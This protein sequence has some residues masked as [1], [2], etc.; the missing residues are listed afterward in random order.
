MLAKEGKPYMNPP[1]SII[2]KCTEC[3][4]CV[5]ECFFL[6]KHNKTPKEIAEEIAKSVDVDKGYVRECFLCSLCRAICPLDLDFPSVILQARRGL[7][8]TW[9]SIDMCYRLSLPDDPLFIID[10]YKRHKNINYQ[11]LRKKNFKYAFFPG[12]A[13]SCYSPEA[14]M[15]IYEML[16]KKLNEVSLIDSC[17]GRPLNDIGLNGRASKWLLKLESSLKERGCEAIITACPSCYYYL[18]SKLQ[19]KFKFLTVYQIVGNMLKVEL[20]NSKVTIHDSCPDRFEGVFAQ[21]V[22]ALFTPA[23]KIVEMNHNKERTMCCG[24]GGLVSCVDPNLPLAAS[25]A[26]AKEFS[27]TGADLMIVYCYVCAQMFWASQPGIKTKHV[28]DLALKT[29]DASEEVK[30]GELNELIVKLLTSEM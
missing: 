12:C 13:M 2:E 24:S 23:S 16:V 4:L 30:S 11:S 8:A 18:R 19:G 10:A 9:K 28:L 6:S 3:R 7:S 20:G 1:P 14:T 25:E 29:R 21:H 17:C 15:R 26:R 27:E 22:R 5:D